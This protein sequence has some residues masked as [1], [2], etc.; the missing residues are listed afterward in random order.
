[1]K[2]NDFLRLAHGVDV[3]RQVEHLV[4]EAPLVVVP[5]HELDEVIVEREAGLGIKDAGVRIGDEVG[6]DDLVIDILDDAGHRAFR[7]SLDGS[8]DLII[9]R[10][11]LEAAGQIDDGHVRAR[12]AHGGAGQLALQGRNDLADRLGSAG[13]GRDD[14]AVHTA[15]QTPVLLGEAVDDL[16]GGRVGMD[17]GHKALDDAEIIVD[18]LGQRRQA[19]RGAGSV[20]HDLDIRGVRIEVNA[21]D[22]H[23]RVVLGRAGEHDDL[24]AGVQMILRLFLGQE[25]AG[26]LE[27]ILDTQLAPGQELRVAVV[28]QRNALAIDDQGRV[29]AAL[30]IDRAVK[31]AVHGIVLH[32]IRQL[33]GRLIRR[34]DGD[35][36]DIVGADRGAEHQTADAAEAIDANFNHALFLLLYLLRTAR[37][38]ISYSYI[39]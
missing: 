13:A 38:A 37:S 22:E 24:R 18:D 19:V 8:A 14:V 25:R 16:L 4:R 20:G 35:D 30:A 12:D 15:G 34:V 21:A 36:L 29:L 5:R 10:S 3:A 6:G 32:S 9:R 39:L 23:R 7:G 17:G 1:M 33:L 27:H 28:E 11:L 2:I 26:A 31:A